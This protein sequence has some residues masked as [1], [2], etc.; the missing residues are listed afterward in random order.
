MSDNFSWS[1]GGKL[2]PIKP[3]TERKLD[4]IDQ[5]L[6]AYFD[7]VATNWRMDRLNITIVDGFCGGGAYS[8]G[9]DT[10]WG[11]P[12]VLLE[13]VRRA[14]ERLNRGRDKH[15]EIAAT[16]H[17]LDVNREHTA[18]LEEVLKGTEFADQ[19][20]K[21]IH[22]QTGEFAQLLPPILEKIRTTQR[23]GRSIFIL[24][25]CGYSDVPML[26]V[27]SIFQQLD[28]A[29]VLLTYSI[30]ALLNY[31]SAERDIS[32]AA[33]QFGVDQPFIENWQELKKD[34]V[35]GR[36]MAQRALM[37]NIHAN[38]A[39]L[40][41]TPFM[42]F[43]TLDNRWMMLAHLSQHQAAR[44]QMLGVHWS[45]QNHFR[46]FGQGS[47]FS[48]GFD[49]RLIDQKGNLFSFSETDR[50]GM[51]REL[52]NEFPAFVRQAMGEA[53]LSVQ[54]LLEKFG[55]HTA[56]RN[57][58]L[59]EV[60]KALAEEKSIEVLGRNGSQKRP[61]TSIEASDILIRPAQTILSLPPRSK[62]KR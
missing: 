25:Q 62:F 48:L 30:D 13:G 45:Q 53:E 6:T 41:F 27:R 17:F 15:F 35:G 10:K 11:S 34:E 26:S 20:G 52:E 28:R 23:A 47:Q 58:D 36:L 50:P 4:V 9:S 2:P 54:R 29:E 38:S 56:A 59:F 44:D 1:P 31:L 40:F 12:L 39:A 46:H 16:F 37:S 60:L 21:S 43:S 57:A 8:N 7:T 61:S 22:I 24:D 51:M 33:R 14:E 49:E 55:N 5:Y 32:E 3:H 18:S 42:M 19:V